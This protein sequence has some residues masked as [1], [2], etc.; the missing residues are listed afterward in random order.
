MSSPEWTLTGGVDA[1]KQIRSGD[2]DLF[3]FTTLLILPQNR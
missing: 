2:Y 1:R 3:E